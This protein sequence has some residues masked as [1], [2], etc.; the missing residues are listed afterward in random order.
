MKNPELNFKDVYDNKVQGLVEYCRKY[1]LKCMVL[2]ISGG[3]DSTV[4]SIIARN[5]A[6]ILGIK[7]IGV[8]LPTSTNSSKEC[9]IANA[10][11][12][13]VCNEYVEYPIED[14]F[15]QIYDDCNWLMRNFT[16]NKTTTK[17]ANGNMKARI[18][19]I[20]LYHIA[21]VMNG[22]VLD[23]DNLTEHELGFFT[24][25]G[26]EGDIGVLRDLFKTDVY[27]LAEWIL[28]SGSIDDYA[29]TALQDS[30]N[31]PATDG[32]GVG[33]D[34]EQF[35]LD[36]YDKVDAVIRG[37]ETKEVGNVLNL[38][39]RSSYK[40]LCRPLYIDIDG[41]VKQSNDKEV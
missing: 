40:R 8:G 13:H 34:L 9:E 2:G 5:A 28:S 22:I 20:M 19:M 10:I 29:R 37:E 4:T 35:G 39:N 23:T 12:L 33:C 30:I 26:D 25:H 6:D 15:M 11:G 14:S 27:K 18:R 36:T 1:D 3:I 32:N 24:I 31:I 16:V 41:N 21:S 7:L 38:H 17:I